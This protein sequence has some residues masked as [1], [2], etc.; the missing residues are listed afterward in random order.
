LNQVKGFAFILETLFPRPEILRQVFA[1]FSG[2]SDGRLYAKRARQLVKM[3]ITTMFMLML[4]F[5]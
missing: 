2:L 4:Y 3:L 1:D 5:T